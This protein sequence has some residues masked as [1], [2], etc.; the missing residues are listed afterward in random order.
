MMS[1]VISTAAKSA[2]ALIAGLCL[3]ASPT[4]AQSELSASQREALFAQ[5]ALRGSQAA[6]QF[7]RC[8]HFVEGWLAQADELLLRLD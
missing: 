1:K 3:I 8:R 7:V 2:I 4:L 6:E 5:A